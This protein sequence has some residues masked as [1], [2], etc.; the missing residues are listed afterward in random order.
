MASRREPVR[1][2]RNTD[3]D[4]MAGLDWGTDL[5]LFFGLGYEADEF[6]KLNMTSQHPII[7][8]SRKK[9]ENVGA[10]SKLELFFSGA[11]V[12]GPS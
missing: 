3:L 6:G 2:R 9:V 12:P 10:G 8:R 1:T 11:I 5:F 4:F 7:G